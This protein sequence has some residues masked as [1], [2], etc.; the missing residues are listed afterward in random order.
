[1][2]VLIN[3]Q[4]WMIG[5]NAAG[6]VSQNSADIYPW[7][8]TREGSLKVFRDVFSP[9]LNNSR[10][11]IVYLPP[12]YLENPLKVHSNVLVMHDGNNLFDPQT[13]FMGNSW[14]IQSTL[15][16]M[17]YQGAIEEVVV[18]GAYNTGDRMYEYTYSFD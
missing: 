11:V 15:N 6:K 16:P 2:K 4:E 9:Q 12:S 13:A 10:D 17:I 8:F 18:I 14:L 5:A 1:M 7:F 3:N